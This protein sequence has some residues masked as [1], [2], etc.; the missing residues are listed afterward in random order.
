MLEIDQETSPAELP[1]VG[2]PDS[3]I[4]LDA[5]FPQNRQLFKLDGKRLRLL[6]PIDRDSGNVS[7]VVF[8]VHIF[9]AIDPHLREMLARDVAKLT[10][11][12]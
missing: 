10:C 12:I 9:F 2:D 4:Q 7:H 5:V 6:Q 3:Q 11:V 8:Q 1:I